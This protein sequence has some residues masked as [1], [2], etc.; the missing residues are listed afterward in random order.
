MRKFVIL[1]IM[2]LLPMVAMAQW[3]DIII[4]ERPQRPQTILRGQEELERKTEP[5][6]SYNST[7]GRQDALIFEGYPSGIYCNG[8]Y[9]YSTD[10]KHTKPFYFS[11]NLGT[12]NKNHFR[13][14]FNYKPLEGETYVLVLG[15]GGRVI[16]FYLDS[17]NRIVLTINNQ[18]KRFSTFV[19]WNFNQ[20]NF[21]DFEYNNGWA[22]I[23]NQK[24]EIGILNNSDNELVSVNYSNGFAYKGWL[25]NIKVYSY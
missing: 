4:P 12:L 21:I 3:D 22:I 25:Y 19:S 16:G 7:S 24:Y 14:T 9:P 2:C 18:N 23:N 1:T 5:E 13:I 6:V 20:L 17:N 15:H 10:A 11:K 8:I